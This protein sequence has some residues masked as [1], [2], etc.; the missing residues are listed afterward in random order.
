MRMAR[1]LPIVNKGLQDIRNFP[2]A[3][4][5]RVQL[6]VRKR[7]SRARPSYTLSAIASGDILSFPGPSFL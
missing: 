2:L 3:E 7:H 6:A 5:P 4:W 1:W